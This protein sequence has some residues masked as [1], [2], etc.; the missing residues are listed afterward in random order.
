MNDSRIYFAAIPFIN[1]WFVGSNPG[2]CWFICIS[3]NIYC[4]FIL[5]DPAM[6]NILIY[7]MLKSHHT[8]FKIQSAWDKPSEYDYDEMGENKT[9]DKKFTYTVS[10]WISLPYM[11]RVGTSEKGSLSLELSVSGVPGHS[12]MPEGETTIATL[13]RAITRYPS[14][15]IVYFLFLYFSLGGGGLYLILNIYLVSF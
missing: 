1:E 8:S 2:N 4:F 7:L 13:A 3:R 10:I 9:D 5:V 11:Y 12:S 6:A 15:K 14:N